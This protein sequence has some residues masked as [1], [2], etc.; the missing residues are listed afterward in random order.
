MR[1]ALRLFLFLAVL[2]ALSSGARAQLLPQL[3]TVPLPQ[4]GGV[5]GAAREPLGAAARTVRD[6]REVRLRALERRFPR[7]LERDPRGAPIVRSVIL[8]LSPTDAALQAARGAG[9]TVQSDEAVPGLGERIVTLLAPRGLSTRRALDRLRRLDPGGQYDFSHLYVESAS[10][11][12]A[13]DGE[14]G[15]GA[16]S[17]RASAGAGVAIGMIDG[18]LRLDH[19]SLRSAHIETS[20]CGGRIV[21]SEHGT[22][23]ASLIVGRAPELIG[24]A[25]GAHLFA[26]DV[27]CGDEAPGG[28][29]EDIAR[30]L[31]WLVESRV[32]LVNLSL[33]GPANVVLEGVVRRVQSRGVLLVAA[34]GNDGPTAPP[35]YP[36]AY[37]GVVAVTA[38][39]AR[40]KVLLEAARGKHIRFAAPGADLRAAALQPDYAMVRGTS[41]AAPLVTGL[42]AARLAGGDSAEAALAALGRTARDLGRKG[43]DDAFGEGLVGEELATPPWPRD[44]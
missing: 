6:V 33:V 20:G 10:P 37:P 41:F 1:E 12:T 15:A 14:A 26:A 2:G 39:D 24:A 30:A 19:P 16:P 11:R 42:L 8:A 25:P 5:L 32:A 35:L 3:P 34:A 17:A 27:W 28:R 43:R 40:R 29:V 38:V 31:G 7:Q 23:V 13:S 9:F 18:G 36:A 4:P 22:A 44:D 21:P